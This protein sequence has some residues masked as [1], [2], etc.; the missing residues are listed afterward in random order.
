VKTRANRNE[1]TAIRCAIY[2]RKST[3][4]GL[5]REFNSLDAQ[6]ESGEAYI[7]SMKHEG[8]ICIPTRYDDGRFTGANMDR[9]AVRRL[10]RNPA[11]L[12]CSAT[13]YGEAFK[14]MPLC[15]TPR[16]G[17]LASDSMSPSDS[18]SLFGVIAT[19]LFLLRL[20]SS[21]LVGSTSSRHGGEKR[22]GDWGI[23]ICHGMARR[24][25][26]RRRFFSR[27]DDLADHE[28]TRP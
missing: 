22:A 15:R 19:S 25:S 20:P 9:P 16:P 4:E 13:P 6:R 18:D 10:I 1:P 28:P 27:S 2:T 5:D 21:L 8:W 12:R 23:A 17:V 3:D 14:R 26:E 24:G 11:C 7:A